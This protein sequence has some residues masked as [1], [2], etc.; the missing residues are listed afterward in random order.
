MIQ[1]AQEM[2]S[3]GAIVTLMWHS[4][5]PEDAM[6]CSP[7]KIWHR[8]ILDSPWNELITPGTK[9]HKKWL[10]QLDYVAGF[11]KVLQDNNIPVNCVVRSIA[12]LR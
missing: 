6:L 2:H 8:Q 5:F 9:L 1:A 12:A 7:A 3:L 4:C 10:D 11:L